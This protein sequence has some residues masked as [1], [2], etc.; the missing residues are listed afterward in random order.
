MDY[1]IGHKNPDTDSIM[2]VIVLADFFKK[3]GKTLIP[4]RIGEVNDESKWA[5]EK[6]SL[7]IPKKVEYN[8]ND[9]YFLVDHNAPEQTIDNLKEEQILGVIDHHKIS[10]KTSIPIFYHAEPL[11]CTCSILYKMYKKEGFEISKEIAG[12]MLSAILSDTVIFK[13]PTTTEEDRKIAEELAKIAGI[14]DIEEFGLEL[15]KQNMQI[16]KLSDEE[17]ITR[18]LKENTKDGY[19]FAIGQIEVIGDEILKRKESLLKKMEE[20][21]KE[22]G[23]RFLILAITDI[24][25]EGSYLFVVGDLEVPEKAFGKFENGMIWLDGVMSRKKQITPPI[26]NA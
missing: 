7:E 13:S 18:D 14:E 21:A 19:K 9:K 23:Y 22:R 10:I 3:M 2:S 1:I 20:I 11:G 16:S 15:K 8:E 26:M 12:A 5:L 17:I 25:K 24:I 6:F 4:G